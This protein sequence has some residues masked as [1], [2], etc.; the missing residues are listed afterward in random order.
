MGEYGAALVLPCCHL[1]LLVYYSRMYIH[2][3]WLAFSDF[4]G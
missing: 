4:S 1:T 2:E 3:S